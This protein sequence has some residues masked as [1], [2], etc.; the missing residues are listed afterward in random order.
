MVQ[1][2]EEVMIA[3]MAPQDANT[4]P[5]FQAGDGD[6]IVQTGYDIVADHLSAFAVP[7]GSPW[8]SAGLDTISPC[9]A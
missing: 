8:F 3:S 2:Y 6:V 7:R 5:I 9:R 1:A 4:A